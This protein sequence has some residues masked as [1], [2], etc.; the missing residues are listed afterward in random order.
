[1]ALTRIDRQHPT[2]ASDNQTIPTMQ[3]SIHTAQAA[4]VLL[5]NDAGATTRGDGRASGCGC[6]CEK[7]PDPT[8]HL[9]S[10]WRWLIQHC[11]GRLHGNTERC[12]HMAHVEGSPLSAAH[13]LMSHPSQPNHPCPAW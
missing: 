12:I 4:A 8:H 13:G 3:P 1:M 7:A 2:F 9:E 6:A 5:G 10:R 11:G